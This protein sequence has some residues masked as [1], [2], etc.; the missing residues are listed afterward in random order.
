MSDRIQALEERMSNVEKTLEVILTRLRITSSGERIVPVLSNDSPP[1]VHLREPKENSQ[2]EYRPLDTSRN[3]FRVM[4]LANSAKDED[5]ISCDL[6]H[7]SLDDDLMRPPAGKTTVE[8]MKVRRMHTQF[9]ALSYTWGG[10]D[11]EGSITIAGQPLKITRNLE[12]A[13]RQMRKSKRPVGRTANTPIQ[14]Y[15]WIDAICINQQDNAE[16]GQ[17]VSCMTRIYKKA[18]A[19]HVWLGEE[20]D[21][22][23]LALDVLRKLG[24]IVRRAPGEA[25]YQYP[26]V[27]EK[28]KDL[29]RRALLALFNR[30]WWERVWVRQEIALPRA[31]IFYCGDATCQFSE[32]KTAYIILDRIKERLGYDWTGIEKATRVIS[33]TASEALILADA[34]HATLLFNLQKECNGG[35]NF[36]SFKDAVFSARFCKATDPRDK[37]FSVLGLTDPELYRL[38]ADYSL[39]LIA[40]YKAAVRTLVA[41]TKSV[42][43][44]SACQNPERLHGFPS[45][46]PNLVDEWKAKPFQT[47][48]KPQ[49]SYK[50]ADCI[51]EDETN[52]L[53]LKG[54]FLDTVH[55][56]SD[57]NAK[58]GNTAEELDTLCSEWKKLLIPLLPVANSYRYTA[59]HLEDSHY[60]KSLL[61]PT[62]ADAT[63][64]SFLSLENDNGSSLRRFRD[65]ELPLDDPRS[66]DEIPNSR[67]AMSLLLPQDFAGWSG[68][69]S[70]IHTHLRN[71]AVGRRLCISK[72]G[73]LG[74]VPEDARIGDSIVV[75]HGGSFP[76]IIRESGDQHVLV[77]EACKLTARL[78]HCQRAS[79]SSSCLTQRTLDLPNHIANITG[80]L[81]SQ[82]FS[83]V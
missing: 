65:G 73:V 13:L 22:S 25:E 51:F 59:T 47:T 29:H 62:D 64:V 17:Q 67:M 81:T 33:N 43:V 35:N 20:R 74:L 45:W 50:D 1:P 39:S 48:R 40:T 19:V 32:F 79:D 69:H 82:Y 24:V 3:E 55:R 28:Q 41:A 34:Q 5:P 53:R 8:W 31:A 15:W 60:V 70:L 80:H 56:L 71:Y 6:I 72:K 66:L 49:A 14:S 57:H 75:F 11:L 76:Y 2:F 54:E 63:W 18:S 38:K 36:I 46:V 4:A 23:T 58:Q 10:L 77:G 83:L 52:T 30:P 26:V 42:D 21:D 68:K 44:L 61:S 78:I 9:G 27:S 37:V 12:T 7:L 16:R